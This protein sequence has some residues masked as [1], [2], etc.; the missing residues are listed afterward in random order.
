MYTK[1]LAENVCKDYANK[2]PI[3][4][5][6]PAIVVSKTMEPLI[7]WT[8]NLN[9]MIGL[10]IGVRL[11]LMRIIFGD[12]LC[13]LNYVPVD[14]TVNGMII[15][16]C[17]RQLIDTETNVYNS[18]IGLVAI[19][20]YFKFGKNTFQS[21][22]LSNSIWHPN[23]IVTKCKINFKIQVKIFQYEFFFCK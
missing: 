22:P 7:G 17:K 3:V 2:L 1:A 11:G 5:Y 20:D 8:N 6:R 12:T 9:S 15:S 23:M 19:G 16:A 14:S 13:G 21:V 18:T 4:I 10:G